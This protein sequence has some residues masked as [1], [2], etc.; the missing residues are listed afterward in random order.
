MAAGKIPIA[1]DGGVRRGS[2][3]FKA[4]AMGATAVFVGRIPI[5]GLAVSGVWETP[6]LDCVDML[7]MRQYNGQ[8]GVELALKILEAEFKLTMGLAGCRTVQDISRN[9]ITY[10][11]HEG[12]LAKL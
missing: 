11:T 2:D 6:C 12:V 9:H 10:L 8:A 1:V 7:T 3:I 5:W 4:I